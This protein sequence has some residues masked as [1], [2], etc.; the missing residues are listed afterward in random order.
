MPTEEEF[1]LYERMAGGTGD[2]EQDAHIARHLQRICNVPE[3]EI[4][5]FVRTRDRDTVHKL[6]SVLKDMPRGQAMTMGGPRAAQRASAQAGSFELN[7]E[8]TRAK[9]R[10]M[11]SAFRSQYKNQYGQ[12]TAHAIRTHDHCFEGLVKKGFQPHFERWRS[13]ADEEKVKVFADACRSL[14]NFV[15]PSLA[16]T[17]YKEMFTKHSLDEVQVPEENTNKSA[18][19]G[20]MPLGSIYNV[21]SKETEALEGR[22]KIHREVLRAAV[23]R[24][25][26]VLSGHAMN[27]ANRMPMSLCTFPKPAEASA[28]QCFKGGMANS[29]EWRSEGKT[30]WNNEVHSKTNGVKFAVVTTKRGSMKLKLEGCV[31]DVRKRQPLLATGQRVSQ[32]TSALGK[33]APS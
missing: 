25:K 1:R 14:R 27:P 11:S 20:C 21:S 33:S 4:T 31:A 17:C 8:D 30:A 6:R 12:D 5:S 2:A 28:E 29:A 23:Q 10:D 19:S 24:E 15:K 3:R 7:S 26:D 18:W 22:N 9:T 16:P 32:S 13:Q